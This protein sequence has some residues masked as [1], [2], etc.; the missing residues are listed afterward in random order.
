MENIISTSLQ[1]KKYDNATSDI[2]KIPESVLIERAALSVFNGLVEYL[3]EKYTSVSDADPVLIVC[4][5][6]N[7]GADGLAV[8]RLLLLKGYISHVVLMGNLKK[9][10][11]ANNDQ[12]EIFLNYLAYKNIRKEEV[13][14]EVN[15]QI[16]IDCLDSLLNN[17]N[18]SIILDGI[19]GIGLS[20]CVDENTDL[21][22]YKLNNSNA[23]KVAIDI[24]S[25]ISVSSDN[26]IF[27]QNPF[28]ADI[29]YTFGFKKESQLLF[30]TKEYCGDVRLFDVGIYE[31]SDNNE[32]F[33]KLEHPDTIKDF[34]WPKRVENSHKGTYK[35]LLIIAGNKE[36]F[37]AALLSAM[38]SFATGIGMVMVIT[39]ENN[40]QYFADK[41]PESI[42]KTYNDN[43]TE[44]ECEKIFNEAVLWADGIL[45][46][47][48]IGLD[49]IARKFVNLSLV[50]S[51]KPLV[52]DADGLTILSSYINEGYTFKKDRRVILTPHVKE[53]AKLENSDFPKEHKRSIEKISEFCQRNQ[54]TIIYKDS[55]SLVVS[56]KY[57]ENY[58]YYARIIDSGNNGMAI[59][60]SGDVLAGITAVLLLQMND[61]FEAASAASYLHGIA[62]HYA[63][64]E[65]G[66][67]AMMPSDIIDKMKYVWEEVDKL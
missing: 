3:E 39:H 48:G 60:G 26:D 33:G 54:C 38:A 17:N 44:S 28:K 51:Q 49:N 63:M 40:T 47:P 27:A 10:S 35:K 56:N 7:N 11:K 66:V 50:S 65:K 16:A 22:L 15:T 5:T 61:S 8:A 4:G 23:L 25:G 62:G 57:S 67:R 20:R 59:A 13:F 64:K 32:S 34:T 2:F 37:G 19:F 6:G 31:Y 14:H 29:T 46:G 43:T 52:I 21:V 9:A 53:Y 42:L 1:M 45:I 58:S 18:Y 41:C 12:K 24:P 30:P 55:V 36:I